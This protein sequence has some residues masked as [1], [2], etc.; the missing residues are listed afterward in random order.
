MTICYRTVSGGGVQFYSENISPADSG[1]FY[2]Q[3][4]ATV[5]PHYYSAILG[6]GADARGREAWATDLWRMVLSRADQIEGYRV[7]AI[8]F[9]ESAEYALRNRDNDQYVSDL[10]TTFF[11][12]APSQS[13]I[14]AWTAMIP[15]I[16]RDGVIHHFLHSAE[17]DL[18]MRR[19]IGIN[20][21]ARAESFAVVDFYRGFLRRLPDPAGM[22]AWTNQ[23]RTAQCR[24]EVQKRAAVI[25]TAQSIS[26][27]FLMTP[28]YV[29]RNRTNAE[30]VTDMYSAF[31]RRGADLTGFQHWKS[32]LDAG[33]M[34][35][36]QVLDS[37]L[38]SSEFSA[39]VDSIAKTPCGG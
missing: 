14:N 24:P 7:V 8:D 4:S 21:Q 25:A 37:F 33:S 12:R 10:Y 32:T 39:R 2:P 35:R 5:L 28:E 16:G 18:F 20:G 19:T 1:G 34:T 11:Q 38:G 9:F 3:P 23:F 30:F 17:F 13:E 36:A 31:L 29:N 26:N 15:S 27:G 22:G 6:R